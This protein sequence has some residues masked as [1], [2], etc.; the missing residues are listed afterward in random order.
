[1]FC[2]N[3][4]EQ[5]CKVKIFISFYII[6][7]IF[8]NFFLFNLLTY[9]FHLHSSLYNLASSVFPSISSCPDNQRAR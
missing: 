2:A 6:C 8:T 7:V 5:I 4:Q 1:M 9:P 3:V